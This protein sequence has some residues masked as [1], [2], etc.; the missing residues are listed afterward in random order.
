MTGKR[1]EGL[2]MEEEVREEG[3]G[4][5]D[6]RRKRRKRR[7]RKKEGEEEERKQDRGSFSIFSSLLLVVSQSQKLENSFVLSI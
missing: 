4:R 6:R 5:K 7:K 3:R 1:R 2:N